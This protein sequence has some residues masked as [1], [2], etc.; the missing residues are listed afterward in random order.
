MNPRM[1]F[2]SL[3]F[4]LIRTY[5]QSQAEF[6]TDSLEA[7]LAKQIPDSTKI[8]IYNDLGFK[9]Y[10]KDAAKCIHF[11]EEGVKLASK[12]KDDKRLNEIK[13]WLG[14]HYKLT[15]DFPKAI[16]TMDELLMVKC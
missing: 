11:F 1:L 4:A 8:D 7:L 12:G 13:L 16:I 6:N 9:W 14:W 10:Q 5:S 3:F 15:G 2:L